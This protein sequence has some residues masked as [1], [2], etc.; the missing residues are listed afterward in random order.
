MAVVAVFL[1]TLYSLYSLGV[2]FALADT[3]ID[4]EFEAEPGE[5]QGQA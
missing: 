5:A 4:V 2:R 1:I 3:Y